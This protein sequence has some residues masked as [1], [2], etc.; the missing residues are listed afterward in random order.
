M[1]SPHP[2]VAEDES[3]PGASLVVAV[4]GAEQPAGREIAAALAAAVHEDASPVSDVVAVGASGTPLP[5]DSGVGRRPVDLAGP[6]VAEALAGVDTLVWL[7]TTTD[8]KEVLHVAAPARRAALLRTCRALVVGAAAAGVRHLVVVSSAQVYGAVPGACV[9]LAE[10][11]PLRAEPDDGPLGDLLA[12]ESRLERARANHPGLTVT[13]VRPAALVGPGV[14]TPLTRHFETPRLLVIR[15]S[16]PVW[17]FCHADD[18]AAAVRLV[19]E[20]GPGS[21]ALAAGGTAA[22]GPLPPAVAVGAPGSIDQE[23]V[24]R[25]SGRRRIELG[26]VTATSLAT[27]LHRVGLSVSPPTE[28]A[29]VTY[30]WVVDPATL[31]SRGWRA[32]YDNETCLGVVLEAAAGRSSVAGRRVDQR[33]V[34]LG[35]ASAAVAL[36][37]TTAAVVRRSRRQ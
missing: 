33:E 6:A 31:V 23:T 35:A 19:V 14:D 25:R 7:A 30:P 16:Q 9:P 4:A 22:V 17:Q 15:G 8:I 20:S 1:S 37:G 13:V 2:D 29:Y 10:G 28:L 34:A 27:Q 24:E 3:G 26:E 18:L 12:V 36:V 32:S 21:S 11:S 5:P